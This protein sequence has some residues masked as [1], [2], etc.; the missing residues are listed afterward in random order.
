MIGKGEGIG[1]SVIKGETTELR[2]IVIIYLGFA[3]ECALGLISS[4]LG[5]ASSP[6]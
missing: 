2:I 6:L 5:V 1:I 4:P 3:E